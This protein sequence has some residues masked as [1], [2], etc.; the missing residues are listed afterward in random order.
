VEVLGVGIRK[1]TYKDLNGNAC[2]GTNMAH[3]RNAGVGRETFF[4]LLS[5]SFFFFFLISFCVF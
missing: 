5:N 1:K 4:F 2:K 3:S